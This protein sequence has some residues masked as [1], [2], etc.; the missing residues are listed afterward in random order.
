MKHGAIDPALYAGLDSYKGTQHLLA[1][2][3]A[4]AA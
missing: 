2:N 1:G 4:E 3:Y